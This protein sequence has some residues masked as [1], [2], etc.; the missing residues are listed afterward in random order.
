MARPKL[1]GAGHPKNLVGPRVREARLALVPPHDQADLA[2]A[3]S[4]VLGMQVGR[5]TIVRLEAQQR[6][7]TD[8]E[9]VALASVLRVEVMWL[10]ALDNS[11]AP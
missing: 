3:L 10:L 2:A 7:V 5:T 9:L 6:P 8:I 11:N 4:R 1:A